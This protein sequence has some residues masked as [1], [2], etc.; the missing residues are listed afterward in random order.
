MADLQRREAEEAVRK[1]RESIT[2]Y[3]SIPVHADTWQLF[4][5]IKH[6]MEKFKGKLSRDDL[7]RFAKRY[8]YRC[9]RVAH[10]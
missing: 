3:L 8:D 10:L 7:K 4:P 1:Y 2:V 5:H 6:V 9:G